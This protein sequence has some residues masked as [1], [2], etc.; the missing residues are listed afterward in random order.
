MSSL[1]LKLTFLRVQSKKAALDGS[2][3]K[4]V[5]LQVMKNEKIRLSIALK[6]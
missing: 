3:Q 4:L 5:T 2:T 1:E 6:D